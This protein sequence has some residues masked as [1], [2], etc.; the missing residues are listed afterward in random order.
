MFQIMRTRAKD[1]PLLIKWERAE[2]AL[3][4]NSIDILGDVECFGC[5]C[6]SLVDPETGVALVHYFC[7][8]HLRIS[9]TVRKQLR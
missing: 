6:Q 9:Y 5:G 4:Q 2:G 3:S 1:E 8:K 7:E